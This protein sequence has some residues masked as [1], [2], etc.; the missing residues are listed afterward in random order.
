MEEIAISF[1]EGGIGYKSYNA[2][3]PT[4][5]TIGNWV[6]SIGID[7]DRALKSMGEE[8]GNQISS[9]LKSKKRDTLLMELGKFWS[10]NNL[11]EIEVEEKEPLIVSMENYMNC[12]DNS[13]IAKFL[14]NFIKSIMETIIVK[15]LNAKC[16]V[17]EISC[18]DEGRTHCRLQ[19]DIK[20]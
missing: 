5:A 1:L 2:I 15:K 13:D 17:K 3:G 19:I 16:K 12:R 8:I 4:M 6:E 14:C 7:T 9:K 18:R 20:S 11:G 10:K